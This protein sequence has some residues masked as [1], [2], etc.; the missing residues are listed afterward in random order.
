MEW[1]GVEGNDIEVDEECRTKRERSLA[2]AVQFH[3][4][5]KYE[6]ERAKRNKLRRGKKLI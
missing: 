5:P 2:T 4:Q 1:G 6:T 3:R